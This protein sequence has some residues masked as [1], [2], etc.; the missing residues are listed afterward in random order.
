M[1]VPRGSDRTDHLQPSTEAPIEGPGNSPFSFLKLALLAI[2]MS[3]RRHTKRPQHQSQAQHGQDDGLQNP[4][5]SPL[6]DGADGKRQHTSTA[7]TKSSREPNRRHMQMCREQFRSRHD[8]S[9]EQ[10][11]QEEAHE[12]R[13]DRGDDE[14]RNQPEQ[15]LH[16]HGAE[17]V[18]EDGEVLAQTGCDEAQNHAANR[19][20]QPEAERFPKLAFDDGQ[21]GENE[22]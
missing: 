20:A 19:D 7:T 6:G 1:G 3:N 9:W 15:N 13:R 10:R 17:Q 16:A 18:D 2:S 11:A 22:R 12:G 14:L 8:H 5:A 21:K 4:H